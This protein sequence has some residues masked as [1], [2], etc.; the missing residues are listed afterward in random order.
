MPLSAHLLPIGVL[1][2]AAVEFD[3]IS[4]VLASQYVLCV[5]S[6]GVGFVF[7]Y[8]CTPLVITAIEG[9]TIG[10]KTNYAYDISV[11]IAKAFN[12]WI[13][14]VAA[15]LVVKPPITPP[16]STASI[17]PPVLSSLIQSEMNTS[18]ATT[19]PDSPG[20]IPTGQEQPFFLACATYVYNIY[21]AP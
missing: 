14:L 6:A 9:S 13:Y 10:D 3:K 20:A 7:P 8:D 16:A 4:T 11:G 18:V 12:V 21:I 1:P 19:K 15:G 5:G 17:T 2:L